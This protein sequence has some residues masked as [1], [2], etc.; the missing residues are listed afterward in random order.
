MLMIPFW[1][2]DA[3]APWL[4]GFPLDATISSLVCGVVALVL[5]PVGSV[6]Q[7]QYGSGWLALFRTKRLVWPGDSD[8]G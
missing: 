1:V 3:T 5:A 8:A 4:L 7:S 2:V 6:D